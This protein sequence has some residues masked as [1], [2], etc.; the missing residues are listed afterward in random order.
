MKKEIR[1]AKGVVKEMT[2]E[3]VLTK[4]TPL[5]NKFANAKLNQMAYENHN[6]PEKDEL[7]QELRLEVWEAY[8]RYDKTQA[9]FSTFLYYRLKLG[10]TRG[11]NKYYAQK[12]NNEAGEVSFS[13]TLNGDTETTLES[14]VGEFDAG[15]GATEFGKF[16]MDLEKTLTDREKMYLQILMSD[17]SYTV[18]NMADEMG[19][20]RQGVNKAFNKF[21]EKLEK[22][23]LEQNYVS[24]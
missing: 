20:T 21:K 2:Y 17:G 7:L 14:A 6:K 12:R 18:Q 23:L 16:I 13:S 24:L 15:F 1:F 4:F 22:I 19:L 10:L 11:T 9:V 3:E 5:M 8:K